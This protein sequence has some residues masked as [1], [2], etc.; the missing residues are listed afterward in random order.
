MNIK[1]IITFL[2][3][4]I[5]LASSSCISARHL[6]A[7]ETNQLFSLY[8]TYF[9]KAVDKNVKGSIKNDLHRLI[10]DYKA[11]Q[12]LNVDYSF[13]D[14]EKNYK[15]YGIIILRDPTKSKI[16][17]LGAGNSPIIPRPMGKHQHEGHITINP[18]LSM[19]PT[20]VGAFGFDEGINRFMK[21]KKHTFDV[22]S[23]EGVTI[24]PS[25]KVLKQNP[26][27][28]EA[29]KMLQKDFKNH[30]INDKNEV[31]EDFGTG[32]EGLKKS[33]LLYY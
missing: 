18:Q 13:E 28:F 4:T 29:L 14:I 17:L 30:E 27:F 5:T 8:L 25:F 21:D 24:A 19:N 32:L 33:N 1:Q 9:Q 10:D 7:N 22:L 20:I 6:S 15:K 23:A 3:L 11:L 16:L 26:T 31:T 12:N 2:T